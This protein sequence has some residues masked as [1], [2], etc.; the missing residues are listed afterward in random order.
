MILNV[1]VGQGFR[2]Y[3]PYELIR[4]DGGG[5]FLVALVN[6]IEKEGHILSNSNNEIDI[7]LHIDV[8]FDFF[9]KNKILIQWETPQINF[10]NFFHW[11]IK[12][13]KKIGWNENIVNSILPLPYDNY[14][15]I[16]LDNKN[17]EFKYVLISTNKNWT[18]PS[19]KY[20]NLY[21]ERYN[22]AKYCC[23]N[24]IDLRIYGRGWD[25]KFPFPFK[26]KN[27]FKNLIFNK[28]Y[29]GIADNKYEILKKSVFNICL[30][31]IGGYNNYIT[32]KIFDSF[33]CGSIPIY[34]GCSNIE[35]YI[36]KNCFISI[37][38]FSSYS[39]LFNY[40]NNLSDYE[41]KIYRENIKNY[42][43]S[44]S[45]YDN[46]SIDVWVNKI[47]DEIFTLNEFI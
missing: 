25:Y 33:F 13:N 8:Q 45:F 30:E 14:I 20:K 27:P 46:F 12:Y 26:I 7:C 43:D 40:T 3:S 4:P 22:I 47:Y 24:N 2:K 29:K 28:L 9:A 17:R 38:D 36:P 6:K 5:Q 11:L 41:I 42:L 18:I 21:K 39:E 1:K 23:E 19:F 35:K 37:L 15:N 31:N 10:K 16:N 32:E 34:L 44:E